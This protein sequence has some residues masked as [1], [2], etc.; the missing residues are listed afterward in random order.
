MKP[1][2]SIDNIV[3]FIIALV[4]CIIFVLLNK[5]FASFFSQRIINLL[6]TILGEKPWLL[7]IERPLFLWGRFTFYVAALFALGLMILI[8][9]TIY[10]LY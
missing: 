6:K 8:T 2:Y 4:L 10:H 3:T 7:K 5:N 9:S 1:D